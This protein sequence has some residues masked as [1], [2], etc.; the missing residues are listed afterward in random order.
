[1]HALRR[2]REHAAAL[3]DALRDA[4]VAV[5]GLVMVDAAPAGTPQPDGQ[6]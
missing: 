2:A 1:M 3:A 6:N 5:S 4:R